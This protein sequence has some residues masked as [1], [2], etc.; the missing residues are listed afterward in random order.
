MPFMNLKENLLKEWV[1]ESNF[2]LFQQLNK[3][4]GKEGVQMAMPY[5]LDIK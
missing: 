3:L 5:V 1:G 4:K 2:T